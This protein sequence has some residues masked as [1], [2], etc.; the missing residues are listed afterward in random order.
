MI[1]SQKPARRK[2]TQK[3]MVPNVA[4]ADFEKNRRGVID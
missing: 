3:M 1:I 4:D 2:A